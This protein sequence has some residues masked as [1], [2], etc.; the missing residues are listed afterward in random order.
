MY[1][2]EPG[3]LG[4]SATIDKANFARKQ[5]HSSTRVSA[6][7]FDKKLEVK[8]TLTGELLS[9]LPQA[10]TANSSCTSSLSSRARIS[11][12]SGPGR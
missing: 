8:Q 5:V 9:G 4:A 2:I 3:C 11:R 1:A 12:S 7:Q 6:I 10:R